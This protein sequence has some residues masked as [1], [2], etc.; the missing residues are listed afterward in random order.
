MNEMEMKRN[1]KG[2]IE[3][4]HESE[5]S[6]R[7]EIISN[8]DYFKDQ[9]NNIKAMIANSE[10]ELGNVNKEIKE[11]GEL[12]ET[13]EIKNFIDM[14]QKCEKF[15]KLRDAK[16]KKEALVKGIGDVRKRLQKMEA[17]K[18]ELKR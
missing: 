7:I 14:M 18:P 15:L 10:K 17:V 3:I 13:E 11:Y 5:N 9:Y 4:M 8:E 16:Q 6:K 12:E 2:K 1:E